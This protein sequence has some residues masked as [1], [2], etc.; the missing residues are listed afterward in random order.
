MLDDGTNNSYVHEIVEGASTANY[1]FYDI[2]NNWIIKNSTFESQDKVEEAIAELSS[3]LANIIYIPTEF[4]AMNCPWIEA[5][6]FVKVQI[7]GNEY[8]TYVFEHSINGIQLLKQDC[9]SK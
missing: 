1:Q 2:S 6:D 3:A 9:S 4:I 7:N 8:N 5:G